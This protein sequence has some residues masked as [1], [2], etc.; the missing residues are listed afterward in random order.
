MAKN[1]P[2]RWLAHGAASG[3][4]D[5]PSNTA[6]VLS[7]AI[8]PPVD[9]GS[10]NAAAPAEKSGRHTSPAEQDSPPPDSFAARLQRAQAASERAQRADQEA[11]AAAIEAQRLDD[12]HTARV[13]AGHARMRQTLSSTAEDVNRQV[14]V[15]RRKADAMVDDAR[16]KA[17]AEADE[18][19]RAVAADVDSL[20][21]E[22]RVRSE[23][24]RER[25]RVATAAADEQ[26][27]EAR[28]LVDEV[29]EQAQAAAT[30]AQWRAEELAR[31][32]ERQVDASNGSATEGGHVLQAAVETAAAADEEAAATRS[33]E[34]GG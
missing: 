27:A 26:M 11:L 31:E 12:E 14:A 6:W 33:W 32:A 23:Q 5:L 30:E 4:K 18:T 29:A 7:K 19:A 10:G 3:V 9:K 15:V 25:A 28:R 22:S 16:A 2:L 17:Q 20:I 13:E 24:A 21:E 34:H 1:N 8:P